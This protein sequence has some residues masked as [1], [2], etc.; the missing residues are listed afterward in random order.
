[1]D[2]SKNAARLDG[3]VA[4]I[5][6]GTPG[7]GETVARTFAARGAAGLVICG[8]NAEQCRKVSADL[9]KAGCKTEY[10]KADLANV[11]ET[12][13]VVAACDKAFGRVDILVN[14]AGITDRGTIFDSSP[15]LF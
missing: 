14:A 4:I 7:L 10:V 9:T 1:M 12:R 11:D 5:T 6:G 15:E 13:A 8:R 2:I 3:K